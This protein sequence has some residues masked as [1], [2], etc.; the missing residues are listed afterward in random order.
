MKLLLAILLPLL[1][2]GISIF[3]YYPD[4]KL[5][6]IFMWG[7]VWGLMLS[8]L[9]DVLVEPYLRRRAERKSEENET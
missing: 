6:A 3:I 1:L 5:I 2:L 9:W 7:T 8:L 4:I